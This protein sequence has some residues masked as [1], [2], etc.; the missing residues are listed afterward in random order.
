LD[1]LIHWQQNGLDDLLNMAA[2]QLGV[3]NVNLANQNTH[4]VQN[5]L[6]TFLE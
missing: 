1:L 2:S 5:I 4:S 6:V 3:L